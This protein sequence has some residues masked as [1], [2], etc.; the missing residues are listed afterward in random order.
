M[1][2]RDTAFQCD[3]VVFQDTVADFDSA[4]VRVDPVL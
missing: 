1:C 3:P 4:D 2:T